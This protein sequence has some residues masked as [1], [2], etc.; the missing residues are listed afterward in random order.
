MKASGMSLRDRI[1]RAVDQTPFVDTHEHLWEESSRVTG[2]ALPRS[3]IPA[4]DF[5]VLLRH[6]TDSDLK[7]SGLPAEDHIRLMAEGLSPKEKWRLVRPYYERCRHTGYQ[8]CIRES[9]RR[10]FDADDI[11]ERNCEAISTRIAERI[12]PGYYRPILRD[13]ANIE[14]AQV[15]SAEHPIFMRT[16]QPDLLAQDLSTMALCTP[17]DVTAI[18]NLSGRE[19]RSLADWHEAIDW[20]FATFGPCAIATKNQA[21][22]VRRLD[23]ADVPAAD[24][25]PQFEAMIRGSALSAGESKAIEDHLFHYCVRKAAAYRL[26]VKL[27]T[28]YYQRYHTMPLD[29]VRRNASDL[30]PILLGHLDAVFVIMHNAYPYQDEAI[31]MAKHFANAYVDMCWAWII[32]PAASVRFLKEFLMAAPACKLF[33]FGGDYLPVELVPG[34]AAI[35][36]QGIA[37]ALC[38]LIEEHWLDEDEAPVLIDRIMRGN[39]HEVFDHQRT[40]RSWGVLSKAST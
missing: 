15:N 34:H 24:V 30:C 21:A 11:D 6:Y 8:R 40:L 2:R 16:E 33:T 31:A 4:R 14:Y 39:A 25:A 18:A 9:V 7:V 1:A 5:G 17:P 37:Q 19:I 10:L 32:N 35:A 13:A 23:Y 22:Y 28:G 27:H 38:E 36:R 20:C 29:R 26:P 12:R 3:P